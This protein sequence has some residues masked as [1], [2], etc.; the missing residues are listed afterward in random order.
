M[1]L[2]NA[3]PEQKKN[4]N[5][6]WASDCYWIRTWTNMTAICICKMVAR[7]TPQQHNTYHRYGR[8]SYIQ[9]QGVKHRRKEFGSTGEWND[10]DQPLPYWSPLMTPGN[11]QE[12][13]PLVCHTTRLPV[14]P[15]YPP[16]LLRVTI[17][18]LE[19]CQK[20]WGTSL[21]INSVLSALGEPLSWTILFLWIENGQCV[22]GGQNVI[23]SADRCHE[24][25]QQNFSMPLQ[26]IHPNP[27]WGVIAN[28]STRYT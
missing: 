12:I 14:Y 5:K 28:N 3:V 26:Q 13:L 27:V 10:N 18:P 25:W 1:A 7:R 19:P 11:S 6:E 15:A 20:T 8:T 23:R 4:K 21:D 9:K 24:E 16:M 17:I 22:K 2:L